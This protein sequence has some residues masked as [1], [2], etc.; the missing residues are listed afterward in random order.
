MVG[1]GLSHSEEQ[2]SYIYYSIP[3]GRDELKCPVVDVM[4]LGILVEWGLDRRVQCFD[5]NEGEYSEVQG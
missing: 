2:R 1:R 3:K 5:G 4:L